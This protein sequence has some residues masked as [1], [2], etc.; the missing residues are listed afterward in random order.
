MERC[1]STWNS[2]NEISA[3]SVNVFGGLAFISPS[4]SYSMESLNREFNNKA[5]GAQ[6]AQSVWD[7]ESCWGYSSK[8]TPLSSLVEPWIMKI[9]LISLTW[10]GLQMTLV[11]SCRKKGLN[12]LI[13]AWDSYVNFCTCLLH[14]RMLTSYL[15]KK[16]VTEL[17]VKHGPYSS[18]R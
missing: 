10:I 8:Y 9:W 1:V 17:Q 14:W 4:V 12:V 11:S 2:K 16:D 13:S 3:E 5:K 6:F 15:G 7:V 18:W